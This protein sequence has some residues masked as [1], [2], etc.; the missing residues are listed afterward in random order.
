MKSLITAAIALS[1]VAGGAS[2]DPRHDHRPDGAGH[3]QGPD[4][5]HGGRAGGPDGPG[6]GRRDVRRMPRRWARGEHLPMGYG[7][8]VPAYQLYDLR[9]PP[10]GYQWVQVGRDF[11]LTAVAT[12][13][14]LDVIP[15]RD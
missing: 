3:A 7:V 13:L 8:P 14:V 9:R 5:G 4:R 15:G 12:G 10:R 11:V 6:D 2:A 1:L